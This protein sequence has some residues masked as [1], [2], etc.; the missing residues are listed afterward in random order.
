[1]AN[2]CHLTDEVTDA[3]HP[4]K[5][6]GHKNHRRANISLPPGGMVSNAASGKRRKESA[7]LEHTAR[8]EA[9]VS[10]SYAQ[11]PPYAAC[12]VFP[13]LGGGLKKSNAKFY[14]EF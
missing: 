4:Q 3:E 13:P 7:A 1:M 9:S 6:T 12:G 14:S 8:H 5:N 2:A 11:A 10:P